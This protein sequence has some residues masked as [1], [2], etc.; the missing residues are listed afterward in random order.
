MSTGPVLGEKIKSPIA[1]LLPTIQARI[2]PAGIA[3]TNIFTI[4]A[5]HLQT[6]FIDPLPDNSYSG[7]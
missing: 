6:A 5:V 3:D 1:L 7:K 4:K 2:Q